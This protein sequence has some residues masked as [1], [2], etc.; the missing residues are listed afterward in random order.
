M[1]VISGVALG[2]ERF[3]SPD[4]LQE[5]SMAECIN[6]SDV[7]ESVFSLCDT[8]H[9]Y[10]LSENNMYDFYFLNELA[11][12]EI[13][14]CYRLGQNKKIESIFKQYV[15]CGANPQLFV[16]L[17]HVKTGGESCEVLLQGEFIIKNGMV[18]LAQAGA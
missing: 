4:G 15:D 7:K 6:Y 2:G 17:P 11:Y 16:A 13:V 3:I 1:K 10:F 18:M 14:R 5:V 12:S 9:Y 8:R